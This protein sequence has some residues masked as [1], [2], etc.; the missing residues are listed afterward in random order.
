MDSLLSEIDVPSVAFA[1]DFK[2]LASL[3]RHSHS[4]MQENIDRISA[5]FQCM[6]MPLSISKCLVT[7]YGVNNPHFQFIC[8]TSILPASDTFVDFGMRRLASG[9]FCE[10]IAIV[11]QKGH[12]L[13]GMCLRQFQ[14][15][16]PDFLLKVYKMYILPPIMYASQLWSPNL[17]YEI[18]ELEAVQH[19]LTKRIVGIREKSYGDR[20]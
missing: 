3:A 14:S 6:Q 9:F 10:H 8:G 18:N 19:R 5:W 15:R 11:A 2:L 7:H 17:R 13:V 12:Q 20:L 16:Q 4:A 1:D